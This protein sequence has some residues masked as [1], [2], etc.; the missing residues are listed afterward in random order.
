MASGSIP[1]ALALVSILRPVWK[2]LTQSAMTGCFES[3]LGFWALGLG[4]WLLIL[5]YST[6][7]A[8]AVSLR[9]YYLLLL[10]CQN[11][12]QS[13]HVIALGTQAKK[14]DFTARTFWPCSVS[15]KGRNFRKSKSQKFRDQQVS[16][17]LCRIKP[18]Q[19]Q[20]P[21]SEAVFSPKR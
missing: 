18:C 4:P 12:I 15:R 6:P 7:C 5:I 8:S 16:K 10:P 3:G 13:C 11:L 9:L 19:A 21:Y 1:L 14:M 17:P 20:L 2:H